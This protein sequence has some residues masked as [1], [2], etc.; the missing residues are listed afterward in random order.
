MSS[1]Q[2]SPSQPIHL[3]KHFKMETIRNMINRGDYLTSI[4]LTDAFLH[5]LVNLSSR[6]YLQ[7]EWCNK[8]FQFRVL[9][10]GMSL[11]PSFSP[12][13]PQMGTPQGYSV[14]RLPRRFTNRCKR[15][16]NFPIPYSQG[17]TEATIAR[18]PRE[19]EQSSLALSQ[20][21]RSREETALGTSGMEHKLRR[22]AL[23]GP[24][25]MSLI[26]QDFS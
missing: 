20:S 21:M 11:S 7:F 6:R 23:A 19:R 4:D 8:L 3:T 5:I 2:S 26:L 16:P 10:L 15:L 18:F 22:L 13:S 1:S 25:Q 17:I 12:S 24:H 9:P 14:V